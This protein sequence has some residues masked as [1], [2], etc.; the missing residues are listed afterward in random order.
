MIVRGETYFLFCVFCH[1]RLIGGLACAR[2]FFANMEIPMFDSLS[3]VL[4]DV[5]NAVLIGVI[6]ILVALVVSVGFSRL[7]KNT[8]GRYI[9]NLLAMG[10]I[11]YTV[12]L[13]LDVAQGVGVVVILGT[14][15]TGALTLGSEH[16]AT[17]IVAGV[18]L[19][20][21]HPFKIGDVV[22]VAGDMGEVV[23]I[24]L[25][26]TTLLGNS[27]DRIIV[28]NS[29]VVIGTIVNY[30]TRPVYRVETRISIP[31]DQDI[32]KIIDVISAGLKNF[33]PE[34]ADETS[35]PGIICGDL[36]D[37]NI[38]LTVYAF[39]AGGLDIESEKMRL[40][41]TCLRAFKLGKISLVK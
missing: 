34:S 2:Q 22:C 41:V 40:M 33:S 8:W 19:F 4:R 35:K 25:T 3:P 9:G 11:I 5:L 26:N 31:A 24:S 32:E 20:A 6:G 30:S 36:C 28:R 27:G 38:N 39:V 18:K 17:D 16:V 13:I 15:L 1:N 29:A 14:A 37:G 12:K 10:I 21:S 23:S 7:T